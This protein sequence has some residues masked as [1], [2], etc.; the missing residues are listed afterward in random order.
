VVVLERAGPV[1]AM[2]R[3][4]R[5]VRGSSW[6]VF[7][8]T[9]L[10]EVIVGIASSMIRVPFSFAGGV[11]SFFGGLGVGGTG[12]PAAPSLVA[13]VS[14]A[15]GTIVSDAVTAP[16]LAGVLV[17]LYTDLRMRR[18]GMD[19]ALQAAAT[20]GGRYPTPPAPDPAAQYEAPQDTSP[21]GP[22]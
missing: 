15:V 1:K 7:G 2:G 9:L 3:S 11:S 19:I 10:T 13:T 5:L 21:P 22:W 4:W 16:L 14:S 18:E 8:I 17:L 6:R 12:H 20:Q